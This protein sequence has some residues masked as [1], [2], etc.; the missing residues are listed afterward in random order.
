MSAPYTG[1]E[2]V[3]FRQKNLR[4]V[5]QHSLRRLQL[6]RPCEQAATRFTSVRTFLAQTSRHGDVQEPAELA[7]GPP[8]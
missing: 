5:A 1:G 7:V 6:A 8:L 2:K 3:R 4:D